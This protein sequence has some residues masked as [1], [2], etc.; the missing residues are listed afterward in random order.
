M[1][2]F[3]G[4]PPSFLSRIQLPLKEI[5]CWC[6]LLATKL[7]LSPLEIVAVGFMWELV[8]ETIVL[9]SV[10]FYATQDQFIE[11]CIVMRC[12]CLHSGE[13][14]QKREPSKKCSV[15]RQLKQCQ[16]A[17]E[18]V[19]NGRQA[20]SLVHRFLYIRL[21]SQHLKKIISLSIFECVEYFSLHL[22]MASP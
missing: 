7:Y 13:A 4:S 18:N 6:E 14:S 12:F 20:L 19:V 10:V 22:V 16:S 3:W 21:R 9:S 2:Y 15:R 8:N 17:T 11:Q 5:M 1:L